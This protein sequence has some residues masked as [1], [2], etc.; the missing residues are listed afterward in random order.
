M[1]YMNGAACM[2][3]MA[4]IPGVQDSAQVDELRGASCGEHKR[5]RAHGFKDRPLVWPR[6]DSRVLC[7]D[8]KTTGCDFGD[9]FLVG[10]EPAR[11]STLKY[12]F[13]Y[14]TAARIA[15]SLTPSAFARAIAATSTK[16]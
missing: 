14:S 13:A 6:P 3:A 9:P 12:S 10:N 16:S 7:Q 4:V 11:R 15:G 1:P 8:D 5:L 2:S